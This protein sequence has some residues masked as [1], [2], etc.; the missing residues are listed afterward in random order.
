[1]APTT[2]KSLCL[3]AMFFFLPIFSHAH[4]GFAEWESVTPGGNKINNFGDSGFAINLKNGENLECLV[5]WFF[6]KN[7]IVGQRSGT[8]GYFVVNEKTFKI[9]LFQTEAEWSS[10]LSKE[11]LNPHLTFWYHTDWKYFGTQFWF[12]ALALFFI[13]IPL[14]LLFCWVLY[15]A[16]AKEKFRLNKPYTIIVIVTVSYFLIHTVG[17][18]FPQSI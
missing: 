1:M 7:N 14:I 3:F 13:T 17:D 16:I 5:K 12:A 6:Y 18:L 2:T 10:Y 11:N 15:K 9:V 8:P 4:V